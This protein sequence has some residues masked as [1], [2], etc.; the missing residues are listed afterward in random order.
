MTL[1]WRQGRAA[2]ALTLVTVA[3]LSAQAVPG[4]LGLSEPDAQQSL[5]G[6]VIYGYPQWGAAGGAFV[7]LPAAARV[8]VVEAGFAWAR[9]YVASPA[10]R[11]AYESARQQARPQPPE[12]EGTVDDELRRQIAAQR[13]DLEESRQALALLAPEQRQERRRSSGRARPSWKIRSSWR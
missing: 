5:L 10:F 9:V 4:Q 3:R 8:A 12:F 2:V 7:A 11:A 6:S 1:G 13:A